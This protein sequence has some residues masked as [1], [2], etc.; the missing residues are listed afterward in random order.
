MNTALFLLAAAPLLAII[1]MGA[2]G[3]HALAGDPALLLSIRRSL[4]EAALVTAIAWPAGV[5]AALSIWGSKPALRRL[6]LAAAWLA[7]LMPR[8][9]TVHGLTLHGQHPL[10]ELAVQA[11]PSAGLVLLIVT[12]VL[13]RLDPRLLHS[14]AANGAAPWRAW[15]LILSS[16][17]EPIALAGAA[18][19]ALGIG[20]IA[21]LPDRGPAL[22]GMLRQAARL[23]DTATAP[24]A[25][26]LLGLAAAPLLA[27]AVLVALS[28]LISRA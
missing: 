9:L 3:L 5:S 12:A 17:V 6:V 13:N 27:V 10:A 19:F 11:A 2:P 16:V 24:E 21:L 4:A 23:G 15:A 1:A 22:A 26:L 18:A 8:A 25:L 14:A 28:R 7:L 20:G